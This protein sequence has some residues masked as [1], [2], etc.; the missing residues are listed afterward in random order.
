VV[1]ISRISSKRI[2]ILSYFYYNSKY[3]CYFYKAIWWDIF[4]KKWWHDRLVTSAHAVHSYNE[5]TLS[6]YNIPCQ[7]A[8]DKDF[9]HYEV[10]NYI[11]RE[12]EKEIKEK[13]D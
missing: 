5:S 9:E 3:G 4:E 12:N 10:N 7:I 2:W 8:E 1:K 11:K 13:V 6:P